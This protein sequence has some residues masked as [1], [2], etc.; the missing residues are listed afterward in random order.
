MRVSSAESAR[1]WEEYARFLRAG[2]IGYSILYLIM[3]EVHHGDRHRSRRRR[4][5]LAPAAYVAVLSVDPVVRFAPLLHVVSP[6]FAPSWRMVSE[7]ANG[8]H[9]W[10]LTLV[11]SA[12]ALSSFALLAALWPASATAL[13][14]VGLLFLLLAGIGQA[15]GARFDVNHPL[16][17]A[18]A[19]IGIPSLCLAA[20]L[21]NL[22]LARH[23]ASR[24]R[25]GGPRTC[26]GSASR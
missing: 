26:R 10:L 15:M 1:A 16:H 18:A 21:L 6:E 24:R 14:K 11:F 19:M 12:W 7:Y 5:W 25:P 9:R 23:P 3:R 13:G 22:A 4:R 2:H 17:G 20:V 8:Q